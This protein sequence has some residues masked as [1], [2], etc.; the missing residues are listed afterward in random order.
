MFGLKLCSMQT[1]ITEEDIRRL[2][3]AL[4]V[5]LFLQADIV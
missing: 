5:G 3:E 1:M 2:D 4:D